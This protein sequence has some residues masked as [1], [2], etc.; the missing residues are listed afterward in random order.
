MGKADD[1][2][3]SKEQKLTV[4]GKVA[5][6]RA[7]A[8]S[9]G[10]G[11]G[12]PDSGNVKSRPGSASIDTKYRDVLN[13]HQKDGRIR[14][15]V[16]GGEFVS[17]RQHRSVL[18][19][20]ATRPASPNQGVASE[21]VSVEGR[22]KRSMQTTSVATSNSPMREVVEGGEMVEGRQ[23]R[24]LA[25]TS[26]ELKR[27]LGLEAGTRW[28]RSSSSHPRAAKSTDEEEEKGDLNALEVCGQQTRTADTR[29]IFCGWFRLTM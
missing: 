15:V 27:G 2:G 22:K 17:G 1:V 24:S 20:G 19:R 5:S 4:I 11:D 7:E 10:D 3:V 9:L 12:A 29:L 16:S 14:N 28:E 26:R 6:Y 23:Q 25:T 21:G 18:I 13:R 8:I